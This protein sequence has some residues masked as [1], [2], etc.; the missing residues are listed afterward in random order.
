MVVICMCR[1]S[2]LFALCCPSAPPLQLGVAGAVFGLLV[3]IGVPIFY[4]SRDELDEKRLEELRQLNRETKNST[5]E[6]MSEEE[7]FA[8]RPPRWTDRRE[9]VDDD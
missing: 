8:I 4:I 3:G 7:I 5:G 6:Y 9:F 1:V 2:F